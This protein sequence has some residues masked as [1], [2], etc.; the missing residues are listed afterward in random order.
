MSLDEQLAALRTGAAVVDRSDRGFVLVT[1]EEA[2][3]PTQPRSSAER[4]Y[5]GGRRLSESAPDEAGALNP[6]AAHQLPE[7]GGQGGGGGVGGAGGLGGPGAGMGMGAGM[8]PGM[9][10]GAGG[11]GMGAGGMQGSTY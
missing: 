7:D 1:G 4:R 11:R 8:G 3:M 9:G 6:G 2:R 5:W 10:P